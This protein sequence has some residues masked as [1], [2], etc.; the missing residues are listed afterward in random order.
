LQ[1]N[2]TVGVTV[3]V[4]LNAPGTAQQV[5]VDLGVAPGFEVVAE[6]LNALVARDQDR[7]TDD[8][9]PR[10]QRYELTGRQILV[11]IQNL[12]SGEPFTFSYRL[13]AKFPI[14][15]QIPASRAYD[16][17]SPDVNATQAPQPVIV[18][19]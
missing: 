10:F 9:A 14:V 8:P 19:P 12:S 6:D 1:V 5:L 15:A 13:R 18:T 3:S 17:Y 4:A 2:D 7:R 16:Y 11:Y